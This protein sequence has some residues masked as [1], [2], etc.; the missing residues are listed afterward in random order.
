ME[1]DAFKVHPIVE[2]STMSY[3]NFLLNFLKTL[4][5]HQPHDAP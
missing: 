2:I 5:G 3:W 4:L 1:M